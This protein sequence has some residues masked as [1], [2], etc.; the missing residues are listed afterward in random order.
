MGGEGHHIRQSNAKL[1]KKLNFLHLSCLASKDESVKSAIIFAFSCRETPLV[2]FMS[3]AKSE[4]KFE[5]F[6]S[7]T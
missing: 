6:D 1:K 2:D 4:E 7:S 3:G 5:D